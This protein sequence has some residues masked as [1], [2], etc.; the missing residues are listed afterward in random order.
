V[1]AVPVGRLVA[2]AELAGGTGSGCA[3]EARLGALLGNLFA[4]LQAVRATQETVPSRKVL[5]LTSNPIPE[6]SCSLP[7]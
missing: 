6:Y 3:V 2:A 4:G 1:K 5:R 7:D